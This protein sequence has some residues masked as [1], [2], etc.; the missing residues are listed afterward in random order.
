MYDLC[1]SIQN[2][3]YTYMELNQQQLRNFAH[4]CSNVWK[5]ILLCFY[6]TKHLIRIFMDNK[7]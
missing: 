4:F 1:I 6:L 5:Y 7:R 2:I 3:L